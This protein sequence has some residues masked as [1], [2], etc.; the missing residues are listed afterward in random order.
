MCIYKYIYRERER[1]REREERD[2]CFYF[3]VARPPEW[4]EI[5]YDMK[6]IQSKIGKSRTVS[7]L[8]SMFDFC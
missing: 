8:R 3:E 2:G 4:G 5:Q 1:A 7:P 6:E